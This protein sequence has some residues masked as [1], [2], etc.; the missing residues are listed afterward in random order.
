MLLLA[1]LFSA[2]AEVPDGWFLAGSK[3]DNYEAE[4]VDEAYS[5]KGSARYASTKDEEG[6]G[7][8]MQTIA[9]DEFVGKRVR[10]SAM[11]KSEDVGSWSGLWMRVDGPRGAIAFDNM[12][13]R[14]I[15]GTTSWNRYE[16]V[17]DVGKNAK[18]IAFG[19]LIDRAG[20]VWLDDLEMEV[21]D[22]QTPLT[23]LENTRASK[24]VNPSFERK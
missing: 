13:D 7:T 2:Q 4:V 20:T 8:M 11:V 21:V 14:P 15:T 1:T 22:D 5:G 24:P 17:L 10:L 18:A 3:P 12:M 9:A 23:G 6:F 19:I 16:I